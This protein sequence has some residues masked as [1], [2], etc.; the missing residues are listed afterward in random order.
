[1]PK[2]LSGAENEAFDHSTDAYLVTKLVEE[3]FSFKWSILYRNEKPSSGA[4][5]SHSNEEGCVRTSL[6]KLFLSR[7][8]MRMMEV[9]ADR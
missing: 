1:M 6:T 4:D 3:C 8:T 2:D 7:D 5:L 9:V